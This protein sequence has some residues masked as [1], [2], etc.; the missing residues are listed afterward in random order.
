[1]HVFINFQI[2]EFDMFYEVADELGIM[3]WHDFM[4][5]CAMYPTN[6]AFLASVG[7]EVRHQVS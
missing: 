5:A 2:Y 1:M 4:F 3:L 6:D 7:A